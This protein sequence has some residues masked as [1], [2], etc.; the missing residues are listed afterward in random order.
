MFYY[1]FSK[2]FGVL[3]KQAITDEANIIGI[4]FAGNKIIN[5]N[6]TEIGFF[7]IFAIN[8]DVTTAIDITGSIF[9]II[10]K[11]YPKA[12][13]ENIIGKKCPPF[14]PDSIQIFVK[15]TFVILVS[16]KITIPIFLPVSKTVIICSSP[17]NIVRGRIVPIRPRIIPPI[18][19]F[20]KILVFNGLN[21][22]L[23]SL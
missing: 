16:I 14:R 10:L 17:E 3:K 8:E 19:H 18:I 12:I 9:R 22:T 21:T 4:K 15:N 13:P 23:V 11:A 20:I 6:T 1:L 7:I 5:S 2:T